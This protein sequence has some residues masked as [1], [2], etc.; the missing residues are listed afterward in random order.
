MKTLL[1]IK[2][3]EEEVELEQQ[4]AK[5]NL[6]FETLVWGE[7]AR[8]FHVR[9]FPSVIV[10]EDGEQVATFEEYGDGIETALH[11]YSLIGEKKK[12]KAVWLKAKTS[13]E[14]FDLIAKELGFEG[15]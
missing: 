10:L 11:D 3:N 8:G 7:G 5:N 14:K 13:A 2:E 12:K 9:V 4:L 1:L 6:E 15:E